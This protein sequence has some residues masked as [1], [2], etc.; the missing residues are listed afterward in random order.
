MVPTAEDV[1]FY[2]KHWYVREYGWYVSENCRYVREHCWHVEPRVLADEIIDR[3]WRGRNV[4]WER[5]RDWPSP[6]SEDSR[7]GD[8]VIHDTIGIGEIGTLHPDQSACGPPIIRAI[9][10][11]LVSTSE[12]RLGRAR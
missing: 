7:T 5:E 3:G 10:A 8:R 11:R 6:V 9:S 4:T 12:I 1:A 2:R